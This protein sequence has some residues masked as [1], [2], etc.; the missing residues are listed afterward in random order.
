MKKTFQKTLIAAA[1]GVAMMSAMGSASA[2]SLLFPYFTTTTGASSILSLSMGTTA[3]TGVTG[4]L[5][6]LERIHYVYNYGS[7][8]THYDGDGFMTANDVMQHSVAS[9]GAGGFGKVQGT[10]RSTPFYFPLKDFGFLTVS[11]KTSPTAMITGEMIVYDPSNGL[12]ASAAGYS[13][14]NVVPSVDTT[15]ANEGN[16]SWIDN[17]WN[18]TA[19]PSSLV[20][21]SCYAVALGNMNT[22]IAANSDWTGRTVFSNGGVVYDNDEF[23]YSGTMTPIVRCSGNLNA[24]N[25]MTTAQVASIGTNSASMMHVSA[26][27][28]TSASSSA[29][30][31]TVAATGVYL[32]K[33]QVIP[34]AGFPG[35]KIGL[36]HLEQ[37]AAW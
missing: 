28:A 17:K 26:V 12:A 13:N 5:A 24:A 36:L 14:A 32:A 6:G 29:L 33:F 25:L 1:A 18:L 30:P 22:A 23:P 15:G 8:C 2:N 37:Q 19:Y 21:T 34:V 9:T 11:T 3:G 27:G 35:G 20:T 31:S 10:D 4:A 7:A 16:F